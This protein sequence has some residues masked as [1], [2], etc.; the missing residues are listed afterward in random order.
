MSKLTLDIIGLT[1]FGRDFNAIYNENDP[2]HKGWNML[3]KMFDV[4]GL[5]HFIWYANIIYIII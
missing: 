5:L 4:S 3:V 1:A 2:L